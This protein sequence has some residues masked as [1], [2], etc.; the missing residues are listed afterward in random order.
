MFKISLNFLGT[1][2]NNA[3]IAQWTGINNVHDEVR[4]DE[5]HL[6]M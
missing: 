6:E 2:G 4:G 5:N 1:E 3:E